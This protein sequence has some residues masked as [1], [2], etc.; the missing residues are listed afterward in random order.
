MEAIAAFRSGSDE[1]VRKKTQQLAQQAVDLFGREVVADSLQLLWFGATEHAVVERLELNSFPCKL[2]FG[3]FVAVETELGIERK[4]AAKLQEKRTKIVVACVD[5]IVIYHRGGSHDPGI[6]LA[7]L[8]VPASFGSEYRCLLLR[9][10]DKNNPFLL[11]ELA[12]VLLHHV[13]LALP[14]AK[15]HQRNLLLRRQVLHLGYEGT[16]HRRH[17]SRGRN[18][19]PTVPTEEPHNPQLVLQFRH[20]HIEVHAVDPLNRKL[21]VMAQDI[22]YPLCY[23]GFG[24]DRSV[25]PLAGNL[26]HAV[27]LSLGLPKLVMYRRSGPL[28]TINDG[29]GR[30]YPSPGDSSNKA[31]PTTSTLYKRP[32]SEAEPR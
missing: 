32:R 23:H 28:L 12:Q 8:R 30:D 25:M 18:R 9:L 2:A 21:H 17:Q 31:P 16:A 20:V 3:V 6:R 24:S 14:L 13:V 27:Q 5:V 11:V 29:S 1:G 10:A 26:T 15:L 22:G 7:G 4:V 19:I